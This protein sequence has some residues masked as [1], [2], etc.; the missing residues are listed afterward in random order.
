MMPGSGPDAPSFAR[1]DREFFRSS[2]N[3]MRIGS[4]AVGGKASG[5]A[6]MREI[7]RRRGDSLASPGIEL[8]IPTM[9]VLGTDVYDAFLRENDL[10]DPAAGGLSDDRIAH[11]FQR[12]SFPASV[13][14]DLRALTEEIHQPLA[15]RSSSL[16]EDAMFRPFAGVYGTKMIPN[17]QHDP[18]IR[19]R[20]LIEAI[21]Y[22]YAST[23]FRGARSYIAAADRSPEEERMAV[24]IQEVI[25]SRFGP[26]FYPHV[27]GV[28]RSYNF[29]PI[30]HAVPEEGVIHLALGLGKTIVD[31][32]VSWAYSPAY[33]RSVPPFRS[34][35]DLLKETQ[36]RFWAVNM[37]EPPAYDPTKETEYLVETDLGA[38]EEDGTLRRIASTYD[39]AS[40]RL[41][42]G[43]GAQGP[44]VLTFAPLLR[45]DL[46]PFN[47]LARRLL[48]ICEEEYGTKVEIEFAMTFS[49][50]DP[51]SARFGFLQV[52]P[53]VVS[54]QMIEV[55]EE[56][57]SA[58]NLLIACES[59][60]GNGRVE[61]I[62]DIVYLKPDR[63]DTAK[64][65]LMAG[66]LE[67]TNRKLASARRP[68]L[69]IGFGRWGSTDPWLGVPVEWGQI[70]GAK[71]I[72]EATLPDVF[73]DPS[74]GA[75]FFH[76]LTS[77]EVSYFFIRHTGPRQIAWDW[78]ERQ[79]AASESE[80]V[81]HIELAAP[82]DVRV[83][84]RTGRGVILYPR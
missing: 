31:G 72:V 44:R 47:E 73:T 16:L 3:V 15:I 45:L 53:M 39:A 35:G 6:K 43:V 63:F 79:P 51:L 80:Y 48:A 61:T 12:A 84:G 28:A 66:E 83:D 18:D 59:V 37:G 70:A 33:P 1:F 22:V 82:L 71:A 25:G 68:Y 2:D 64:T 13:L 78:I 81:R 58:P 60:L 55:D 52:R 11:A 67:E 65:R 9:A 50:G 17:N 40:D 41:I 56:L 23:H 76:N 49:E 4:G 8:T 42:I 24:I 69:L 7:L 46:V 19:F 21:K 27:S 34:M 5:L 77:F 54:D 75:H 57:F 14:G 26:R 20:K 10:G 30:G 36:I 32:G 38:A 29:Y 74:Q 62:R